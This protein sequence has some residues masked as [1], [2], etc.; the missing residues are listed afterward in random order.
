[1]FDSI[2]FDLDGTLW[3]GTEAIA[4]AWQIC[5]SGKKEIK[6]IP[7]P[8]ELKG[9]MGLPLNEIM[10]RLFPYLDEKQRNDLIAEC[11]IAEHEY[12]RKH[13]GKLFENL[14]ET[15]RQL[16]KNEG[17]VLSNTYETIEGS[18]EYI[19]Y[20]NELT[21][22][23]VMEFNHND[24]LLV[25]VGKFPN[26]NEGESLRL[27]GS[28]TEHAD[29]GEQ[30]S[31]VEYEYITP[32]DG[33]A[34]IKYLS[35]GIFEGIGPVTAQRIVDRFGNETLRVLTEAPGEL[36][37]IKGIN[38]DKAEKICAAYK[39]NFAYG[40]VMLYLKQL[41]VGNA[42]ASKIY[43][44]YGSNSIN[45]IEKDPYRMAEEIK[46]VGFR[47]VDAMARKMGV[48][49]EGQ[50]RIRAAALYVL[51]L[52][53]QNGHVYLPKDKLFDEME[54][55]LDISSGNFPEALMKLAVNG[56]I[57]VDNDT[58]VYLSYL[59]RYETAIANKLI[60][61]ADTQC[62][63][64][65]ENPCSGDGFLCVKCGAELPVMKHVC[66]IEDL[67]VYGDKML[68]VY[69]ALRYT[70]MVK[71][72]V[73]SMKYGDKPQVAEFLGGKMY[74]VL[75]ESPLFD[76]D[77]KSFDYVVPVPAT[78]D[79]I[80]MRGYNQAELIAGSFS[81]R[82]GVPLLNGVIIKNDN[83]VSQSTLDLAA[84]QK[85]VA[86]V[87]EPGNV[88]QILDK[89]I[90]LADDILTTGATTIECA[91]ILYKSGAGKIFECIVL[92]L[93]IGILFCFPTGCVP[94]DGSTTDWSEDEGKAAVEEAKSYNKSGKNPV[95]TMV[96]KDYGTVTMELYPEKAPQSVYNFIS[97]INKNFYD[98]V[99]FHRIISGFMV[100]G[101]DPD[102]TGSG[103]ARVTHER[104]ILSMAR[105]TA[106]D[107]A[108][109][110]FFIMH[111]ASTSLDGKYAAFGKVLEGMD[112]ID[113]MAKVPVS[114]NN[115]TLADKTQAPVI[116]K[117]TVDTFGD[118]YPEPE[119]L[120]K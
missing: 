64:C 44:T 115:G 77:F 42:I 73:V 25:V 108:G 103:E 30:F 106:A 104:G 90:I 82:S 53:T 74:E 14:E 15:L 68:S 5:M 34:L 62:A 10:M 86:G 7:G 6:K 67:P 18:V 63:L 26:L 81:K 59:Y 66:A 9:V 117:M 2:G 65:G 97:L 17:T 27:K 31:V 56:S 92:V 107:S 119:K 58:D 3:D 61:L 94:R 101:G 78:P 83:V 35:S 49:K 98:G 23:T 72:A 37:E 39:E 12:I 40:Q 11:K 84:R 80:K 100:Q 47:T 48:G 20:A 96:V 89:N 75:N 33:I 24:E 13:G 54:Q 51:S 36:A 118:E 8:D 1:M 57:R 76:I 29:Y 95:V 105:S 60:N 52:S 112:V 111:A 16:I 87:Y 110:Q 116:E 93:V 4:G 99:I 71:K 85:S 45:I 50:G 55:L 32:V 88:E 22:Y 109:S 79:K 113:E 43:K 41:D 120:A 91:K 114:D 69:C 46:G 21:G 102:G 38:F 70:G 19:K 28:F